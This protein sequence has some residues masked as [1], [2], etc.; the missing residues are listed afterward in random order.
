MTIRAPV[1]PA[2]GVQKTINSIWSMRSCWSVR[3]ETLACQ[4]LRVALMS[5]E[6]VPGQQSC[7]EGVCIEVSH[8]G[9]VSHLSLTCSP[10]Y[11]SGSWLSTYSAS[12]DRPTGLTTIP[13]TRENHTIG[14]Q[15]LVRIPSQLAIV[16]C[17]RPG[18]CTRAMGASIGRGAAQRPS[19][20]LAAVCLFVMMIVRQRT[21]SYHQ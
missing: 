8:V 11:V 6:A 19:F 5:A 15:N 9:G 10:L 13:E 17:G 7:M 18:C 12:V 20:L 3:T 1:S 2:S 4:L 21:S 14:N 16:L